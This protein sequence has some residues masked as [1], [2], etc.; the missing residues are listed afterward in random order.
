M[1]YFFKRKAGKEYSA[2]VHNFFTIYFS[3]FFVKFLKHSL[4]R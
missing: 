3:L 4:P 1:S 2:D